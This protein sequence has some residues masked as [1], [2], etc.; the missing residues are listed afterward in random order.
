MNYND[1]AAA[2]FMQAP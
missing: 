2:N 1:L